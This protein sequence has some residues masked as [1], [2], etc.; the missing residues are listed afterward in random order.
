MLPAG[1]ARFDCGIPA[2]VGLRF[3]VAVAFTGIGS[4]IPLMLTT[5]Q[6]VGPAVAGTSLAVTG[7]FWAVGSWLVALDRVQAATTSTHRLRAGFAAITLGAIGPVLLALGALP[8]VAGMSGW[9]LSALGMGII[10]PTLS[11]EQLALAADAEQGRASAAAGLA[12]SIGV[13]VPTALAGAVVALRGP[14]MD[15]PS[16]AALMVAAALTA[17]VGALVAGRMRRCG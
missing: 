12:G 5:T 9:A 3:V 8:L 4:T 10:S 11:T 2:V 14:A 6:G 13:A 7:A 15:G 17:A 16:Y 1:T